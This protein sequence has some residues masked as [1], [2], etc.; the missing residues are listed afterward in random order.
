M[1]AAAMAEP[2][3]ADQ[4]THVVTNF[5]LRR[6]RGHDE[7]LL[8]QRSGR[9]RTYQGAWAGI[10]GYVEPGVTPLQQAYTELSEEARL[11]QQD[12]RL[13]RT[14]EPLAFR[15]ESIQQSWVVHPFLFEIEQ[16]ERVRTDWEATSMQWVTPKQLR[17][18]PT[19]P[20]LVEALQ[21][22]YP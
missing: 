8:V 14:G 21:R 18:L 17:Q 11:S 16:P 5:V 10:S 12:L 13:L 6:D 9:V 2:S 7:L 15:D 20:M 22:V 19:V 1:E 3:D 4:A